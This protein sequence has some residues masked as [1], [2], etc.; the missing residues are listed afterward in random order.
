MG[1][2]VTTTGFLEIVD[3][4]ATFAIPAINDNSRKIELV[5]N[6]VAT[7]ACASDIKVHAPVF[8]KDNGSSWVTTADYTG[9]F[10]GVSIK[11][12]NKEMCEVKICGQCAIYM[13]TASVHM[14]DY[15]AYDSVL[16]KVVAH[17]AINDDTHPII[18]KVTAILTS[19]LAEVLIKVFPAGYALPKVV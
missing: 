9:H 2:E 14:G 13:D 6:S 4:E 8:L 17:S 3:S 7:F 11:A 18:G 19:Y 12:S 15:V 16:R 10:A 1:Y 5:Q